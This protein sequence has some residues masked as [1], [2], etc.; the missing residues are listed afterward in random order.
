MLERDDLTEEVGLDELDD[1][2]EEVVLDEL[3]ELG[4][5]NE[6]DELIEMGSFDLQPVR[7]HFFCGQTAPLAPFSLLFHRDGV[8]A[9]SVG[10][11]AGDSAQFK[12][13]CG[14]ELSSRSFMSGLGISSSGLFIVLRS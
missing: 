1:L 12:F 8:E 6:L 3:D 7:A 9:R 14:I 11:F 4:G 10:S 5:V 13:K 2:T